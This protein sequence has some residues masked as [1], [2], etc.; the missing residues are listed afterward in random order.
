MA[1]LNPPRPVPAKRSAASA[2]AG[3]SALGAKTSAAFRA[4]ARREA[5]EVSLLRPAVIAMAARPGSSAAVR[6]LA[7]TLTRH[8]TV[9]AVEADL[10]ARK[11]SP[12]ASA[13]LALLTG[14]RAPQA[15]TTRA[16][17]RRMAAATATPPVKAAMAKTTRKTTT[18]TAPIRR[19]AR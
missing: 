6:T 4:N 12:A 8:G 7:T 5:E 1:R 10:R 17:G 13:A 9:K 15:V 16:T 19:T 14:R 3:R 2:S 11:S 18:R